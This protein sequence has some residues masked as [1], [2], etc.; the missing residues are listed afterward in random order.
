MN[1]PK[2]P[3]EQYRFLVGRVAEVMAERIRDE[4]PQS[5]KFGEL[6]VSFGIPGTNNKG[7]MIV[8]PSLTASPEHRRLRVAVNRVGSD[9]LISNYLVHDTNENI[10]KYLEKED[11][12]D[13]LIPYFKRLSDRV[14]EE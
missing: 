7:R 10:L 14:D 13:E 1:T 2:T 3:E 9:R 5:G 12:V 6:S 4:V 8:E 11:I